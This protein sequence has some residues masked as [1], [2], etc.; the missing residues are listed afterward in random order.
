[1]DRIHRRIGAPI[2]TGLTLSADVMRASEHA[3]GI[4][5]GTVSPARLPDL[6]PG[7]PL[8]ITGRYQGTVGPVTVAGRTREGALW[9]VTATPTRVDD[10]S[11]T[12]SWARAHLRDLEDRFAAGHADPAAEQRIVVTSLRFG[13]LCRFTAWLAVDARVVTA[14]GQPH[15]VVQP[16]ELPRGWEAALPMSFQPAGGLV[17]RGMTAM[18]AAAPKRAAPTPFLARRVRAE[19]ADTDRPDTALDQ[20]R[21][22]AGEEAQRLRAAAHAPEADRRELLADLGSRLTALIRHLE[23]AGVDATTL[24]PVRALASALADDAALAVPAAELTG[25]WERALAVLTELA[26]AEPE[27][28]TRRPFWKA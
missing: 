11:I 8:V 26:R 23:G 28:R 3:D 24:A 1:M 18:V 9:S 27:P 12:S 17:G 2:V 15:Q 14:G 5:D 20:A 4:I 21:A 16:V 22:Q 10:A 25:L 6:F 19:R 7:V 13:V